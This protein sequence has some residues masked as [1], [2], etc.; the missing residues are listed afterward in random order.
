MG[1]ERRGAA[2]TDVP[3]HGSRGQGSSL[4]LSRFT[5]PAERGAPLC[6]LTQASPKRENGVERASPRSHSRLMAFAAPLSAARA[7]RVV[8]LV[9][10][11]RATTATPGARAAAAAA[12][13]SCDA[14]WLEAW[15]QDN[16]LKAP[17][18][19]GPG[20]LATT[21]HDA[22]APDV[23]DAFDRQMDRASTD[24]PTGESNGRVQGPP[25]RS[26][27]SK[28]R[29]QTRKRDLR[30]PPRRLRVLLA[31]RRLGAARRGR[32]GRRPGR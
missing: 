3:T 1:A 10:V 28:V 19:R 5:A 25:R 29:R 24:A 9:A 15:F 14:D 20:G 27:P 16:K 2:S 23:A 6:V 21:R 26:L 18:S 22:A 7:L 13:R 31:L 11:L 30:L 32:R 12:P 4:L 8:A 17:W